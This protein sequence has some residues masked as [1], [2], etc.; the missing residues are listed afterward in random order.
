MVVISKSK[1]TNDKIEILFLK[2]LGMIEG[3]AGDISNI[4]DWLKKQADQIDVR[5]ERI[6]FKEMKFWSFDAEKRAIRHESCRFF[7]IEGIRVTTNWGSVLSW[8]QPIIN[9]PEIG[10]LGFI[11]KEIDG[12]LHFLTQA[13]IE[14][15]NLN[16][17]QLSPTIQATRSNYTQVHKGNRPLYLEYF[18]N[19]PTECILLD[20]LQSEQG[21]RFLQKRNRNII[22]KFDGDIP[23]F[24]NFIW[25]TLGQ[26]KRLMS[27][28]NV[29]NMDARTV[30]SG[31][32]YGEYGDDAL[33]MAKL[34][35]GK[36]MGGQSFS[37]FFD[38]ALSPHHGVYSLDEV[39]HFLT[40][41]KSRYDLF[42]DKIPLGCVKQWQIKPN[43]I[44][45]FDGKYFKVIAVDV[46][47]SNREVVRWQ[48][49][50]VLPAQ[51]GI[52]AFICK[53]IKG[54]VH[55]AVQAKLECGNKDIIELAPTVQ[56]LT[57]DYRSQEIQP[58]SF[59]EFALNAP[60]QNVI[61][62]TLQSEEGGRFYREQNRNLIILA[63]DDFPEKLPETYI[64]MTLNQLLFFVKLN[65]YLNI[66]ARSLI[67][68]ISLYDYAK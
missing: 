3:V 38:S 25:L 62:D 12:V 28:D 63:N 54:V 7:S 34:I 15:G 2:S 40:N 1:S 22:I 27:Y 9:Q 60:A 58:P 32:S 67:A 35:A 33:Q 16:H 11:V 23:V 14:P 18:I 61:V 65:N 19:A 50:M 66:Q 26:L 43:E 59:L 36:V 55:F 31:I 41:L 48:Q 64:W 46:F 45:R 21:S 56:C 42:I 29:V 68:A 6:D 8:D 39:L 13:K 30:I 57:G 47:I 53:K 5:I 51:Q 10:Y 49:P 24:D 4:M 17:V 44:S 20:Q 52:C 37:I